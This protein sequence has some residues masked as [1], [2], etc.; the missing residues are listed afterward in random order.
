MEEDATA[1]DDTIENHLSYGCLD[2]K[3]GANART[4]QRDA[5]TRSASWQGHTAPY[6]CA[7]KSKP[8]FSETDF[9]KRPG[10]GGQ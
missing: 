10:G 8:A 7:G 6:V 9:Q 4:G 1:Y 3:K 2:T 5:K